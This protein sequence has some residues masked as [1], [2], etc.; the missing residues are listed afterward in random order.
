[1]D[2]AESAEPTGWRLRLEER[3]FSNRMRFDQH[4]VWNWNRAPEP[5]SDIPSTWINRIED[6]ELRAI[7]K[8]QTVPDYF[9]PVGQ[10]RGVRLSLKDKRD[11]EGAGGCLL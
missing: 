4:R 1:V 10:L 3:K 7:A 8:I 5:H 2:N 6:R 11:Q 9:E